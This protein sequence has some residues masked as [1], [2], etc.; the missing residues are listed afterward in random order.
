M[1]TVLGKSLFSLVSLSLI[2]NS[3]IL[4]II[5]NSPNL[6]WSNFLLSY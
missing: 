2:R 4:A 3:K 1:F 5:L 6:I